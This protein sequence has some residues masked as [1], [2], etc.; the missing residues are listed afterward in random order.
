MIFSGYRPRFGLEIGFIDHLQDL[1]IS[2]YDII[3]SF[4]TLQITTAHAKSS[5]SVFTS[6]F[7]VTEIHQHLCV[8]RY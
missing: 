5:Q 4:D 2:N 1:S 3:A 8:V 6:R 7:P